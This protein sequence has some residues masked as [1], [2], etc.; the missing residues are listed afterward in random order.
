[1]QTCVGTS[2]SFFKR[3]DKR[4]NSTYSVCNIQSQLVFYNKKFQYKD[5]LCY[6]GYRMLVSRWASVSVR[7]HLAAKMNR[8][9]VSP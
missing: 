1:M 8:E 9:F 6:H 7:A 5:C 3:K 4:Q 2:D